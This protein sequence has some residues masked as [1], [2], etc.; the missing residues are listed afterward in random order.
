MTGSKASDF[1][2][3]VCYSPANSLSRLG[4]SLPRGSQTPEAPAVSATQA[5][6]QPGLSGETLPTNHVAAHGLATPPLRLSRGRREQL[7][8]GLVEHGRLWLV[9]QR[10]PTLLE[11]CPL[12]W[13]NRQPTVAQRKPWKYSRTALTCRAV[14]PRL[15]PCV[16]HLCVNC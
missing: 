1:R 8:R 14:W 11:Q 3:P 5:H 2:P 15:S 4:Y 10:T 16:D 6:R 13:L 9:G 12:L 7:Q